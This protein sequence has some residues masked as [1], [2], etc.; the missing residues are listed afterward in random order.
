[1]RTEQVL[2]HRS[3]GLDTAASSTAAS[4]AMAA[5]SALDY[6]RDAETYRHSPGNFF[7]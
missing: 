4:T 6:Y 7:R 2:R 5:A 1:M 3:V